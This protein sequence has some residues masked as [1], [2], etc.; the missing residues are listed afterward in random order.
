MSFKSK[1]RFFC[2]F[3]TVCITMCAVLLT[4][5]A[6]GISVEYKGSD[7]GISMSE[8]LHS[9]AVATLKSIVVSL[10]NPVASVAL[11]GTI[12]GLIVSSSQ[13]QTE[14]LLKGVKAIIWGFALINSLGL[15]FT[16]I[17]GIVGNHAYT[18]S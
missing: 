2:V 18:F 14:N 12:L 10:V 13:R 3:T 4:S 6:F 11:G 15:I 8:I 9:S 5:T 7:L 16:A 17:G 1:K